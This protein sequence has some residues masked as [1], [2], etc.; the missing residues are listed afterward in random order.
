MHT[1]LSF[2]Y[3]NNSSGGS[4]SPPNGDFCSELLMGLLA[5][6]TCHSSSGVSV[7]NDIINVHMQQHMVFLFNQLSSLHYCILGWVAKRNVWG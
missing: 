6:F 4:A 1:T 3:L 5:G 2:L 7:L